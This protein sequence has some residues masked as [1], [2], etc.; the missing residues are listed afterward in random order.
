MFQASAAITGLGLSRCQTRFMVDRSRGIRSLCTLALDRFFNM[1]A[2][3]GVSGWFLLPRFKTGA[4]S[5]KSKPKN[6]GGMRA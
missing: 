5:T 2:W 3:R 1:A 6:C 4:A